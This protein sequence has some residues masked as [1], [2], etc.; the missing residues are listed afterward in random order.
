MSPA[1]DPTYPLF[2]V[3]SFI[4]FV[5]C[6]IPLPWHLHAWNSGTCAFMIWTALS[7]LVG[8]VNSIVWSGNVNNPAPIWCDISSKIIIGVS[9]GIPAATL[10]ISRRL[11]SLTSVRTVS[12]TRDD[13]RR[14]VIIDLCISLGFPVLIMILHYIIQGHRFDIL[15]DIGCYPVVYNTLPSYFLYF[16]WP[17]FLGVVSFFY[18]GLTLRGFWMRRLQFA[19]L[20]T[21]NSSMNMSRYIRL[22]SLSIIDMMCTVPLGVYSIYIGNKGVKLA[23]WISWEDTHFNFSRVGVVPSLI[24]RSDP[25]FQTSVE[26]TRWLPV[27][28]AFLFFALFGFAAEAQ[29]HYKMMFTFVAKPL[30]FGQP[31]KVPPKA[32]LPGY[33]SPVPR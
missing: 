33:V 9:I 23:P 19:Q 13:K 29:K 26:L 5:L 7:C 28:C 6:L 27:V 11:Y 24:W 10:C 17:V 1:R 30:G 2:P 3:F 22:M 31:P 8:F 15:E 32:V 20:V 18:S 12:I 14:M 25:S 21:S 4:G 16:M